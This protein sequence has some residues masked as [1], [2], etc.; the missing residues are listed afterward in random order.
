MTCERENAAVKT[1]TDAEI[2]SVNG[3]GLLS[4]L[5]EVTAG[6]RIVIFGIEI[7]DGVPNN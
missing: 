7:S 1:L 6:W 3:A 5:S 2:E 4:W